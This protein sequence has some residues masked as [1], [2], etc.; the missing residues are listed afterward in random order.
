MWYRVT[1]MTA[2][3]CAF[4][5]IK[6]YTYIHT[7]EKERERERERE[8]ERERTER[9]PTGKYNTLEVYTGT[10]SCREGMSPLQPLVEVS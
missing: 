10:K 7:T 3:D 8:K 5:Q 6:K 9:K 2:P 1:K 4:V